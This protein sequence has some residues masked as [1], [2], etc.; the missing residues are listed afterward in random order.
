ME[1]DITFTDEQEEDVSLVDVI[2]SQLDVIYYLND[3]ELSG[4]YD[5]FN[6]DK[7]RCI[8]GCFQ[9]IEVAQKALRKKIREAK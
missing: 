3:V 1:T 2:L 9:T 7:I 6:E 8:A 4:L 5:S